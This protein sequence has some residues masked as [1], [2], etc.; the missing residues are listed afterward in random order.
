MNVEIINEVGKT[1]LAKDEFILHRFSVKLP[2]GEF[3]QWDRKKG[4]RVTNEIFQTAEMETA[5]A[6]ASQVEGATLQHRMVLASALPFF[7]L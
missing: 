6:Y 4:P 3:L 2:S 5:E 7:T 1:R